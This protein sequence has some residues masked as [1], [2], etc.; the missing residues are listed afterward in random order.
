MFFL[1]KET[2]GHSSLKE[3]MKNKLS[4]RKVSNSVSHLLP[5]AVQPFQMHSDI[6]RPNFSSCKV[7]GSS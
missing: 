5:L 3:V 4:R 1:E 7:Q 2:N 6:F